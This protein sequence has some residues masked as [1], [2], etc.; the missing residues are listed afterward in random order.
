[1]N[2]K[3]AVILISITLL[4]GCSSTKPLLGINEGKLTPCPSTPN[5]LNSQINGDDKHQIE[6]IVYAGTLTEAH[7]ALV[8]I[9]KSEDHTKTIEIE[10]NYI[11]VEYTST[12]FQFVDDVEFYFVEERPD[13]TQIHIRSAS[14]IGRSDF[15]VNRTR[16]ERIRGKFNPL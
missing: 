3:I 1:M 16:I 8:Q 12:F 10:S 5:C 6:S 14:R 11:H 4:F 2:I 7:T 15:G 9:L 13:K